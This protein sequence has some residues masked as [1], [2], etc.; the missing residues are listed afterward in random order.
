MS[1]TLLHLPA[2]LILVALTG[3]GSPHAAAPAATN[4][5]VALDTITAP[6]SP[7]D[8]AV[9]ATTAPS[10]EVGQPPVPTVAPAPTAEQI[11]NSLEYDFEEMVNPMICFRA[12][13]AEQGI[14]WDNIVAAEPWI[15]DVIV[16]ESGGCPLLVGGDT[17]IPVGCTPRIRGSGS[18]VGWGQATD[19]YWG[20]NGKLCTVYGVCHPWQI[21][22]SPYHSMLN[23]V[24]R[25]AMLDGRYGYCDYVGAPIYHNCGLVSRAWRLA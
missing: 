13:A 20:R 25:V 19:S 21:L 9:R 23:S 22:E 10:V 17:D 7:A 12:V 16:K 24:V 3:C 2:A 18:D 1:G 8:V 14:S 11:C 6:A 4:A 5:V 15:Y